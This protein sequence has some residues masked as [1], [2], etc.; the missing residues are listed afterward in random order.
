MI[1]YLNFISNVGL[2]IQTFVVMKW[3]I[4]LNIYQLW[5]YVQTIVPRNIKELV[6]VQLDYAYA[7]MD[8]Q[9]TIAQNHHVR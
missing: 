6:I 8:I 5:L 9:E 3:K 7:T 1:S 2:E 4:W